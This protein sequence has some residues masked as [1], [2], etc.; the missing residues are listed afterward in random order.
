MTSTDHALSERSTLI[1][2][3][4]ALLVLSLQPSSRSLIDAYRCGY[5]SCVAGWTSSPGAS[6][7]RP[8][9]KLVEQIV[10]G[11]ANGCGTGGA[12]LKPGLVVVEEAA[13]NQHY[14]VHCCGA[15]LSLQD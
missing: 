7:D 6:A 5:N 1:F 14:G 9:T 10:N 4:V 2:F 3:L 12:N 11:E 15:S 8:N 13:L